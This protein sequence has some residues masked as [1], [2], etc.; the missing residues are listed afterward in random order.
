MAGPVR[1]RPP[2]VARAGRMDP[3]LARALGLSL[4]LH[5]AV[6][7]GIL[8]YS[9]LGPEPTR[10]EPPPGGPVVDL[11]TPRG[12][13]KVFKVG[14]LAKAGGQKATVAERST[15]PPSKP[16]AAT[17][18]ETASRPTPPAPAPEPA[19]PAPPPEPPAAEPAPPPEPA[20]PP[21]PKPVAKD[22]L[23]DPKIAEEKRLAEEKKQAEEKK[24]AEQ[25]KQAEEKKKADEKKLADEKKKAEE[26]KLAD[27]KK[28]AEEKKLADEKKAEEKRLADEKKKAEEKLAEEKRLATE[29]EL[30]E[31]RKRAE[32][33]RAAELADKTTPGDP[34][35]TTSK[36]GPALS[37]G[38]AATEAGSSGDPNGGGGGAGNRSP[39]FYAYYGYMMRTIKDQWVWAGEDASLVATIRF[40]ILPDGSLADARITGRSRAPLYDESALKAVRAVGKLEPP[41]ASVAREFSDIELDFEAGELLQR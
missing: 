18:P 30:A 20:K 41:P 24:L 16:E 15:P 10:F 33:K 32:E 38:G 26:K 2:E 22:A 28:K 11:V 31:V 6:V 9:L 7:A 1:E 17:E 14:P 3:R 19:K 4:G 12:D 27:E 13:S 36:A 39:E 34:G 37:G 25:K 40:S 8:L 5:L 21:E 29:R 23:P 35:G